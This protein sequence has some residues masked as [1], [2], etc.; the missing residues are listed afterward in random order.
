[1]A[2]NVDFGGVVQKGGRYKA[3]PRLWGRGSGCLFRDQPAESPS[4]C[5]TWRLTKG[6]P[7]WRRGHQW[8]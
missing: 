5:A 1:M 2:E 7:A 6:L 4:P 8:T 3:K